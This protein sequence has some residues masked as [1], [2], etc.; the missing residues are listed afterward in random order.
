MMQRLVWLRTI[1]YTYVKNDSD[2]RPGEQL[3]SQSSPEDLA[4]VERQR[5][6]K[7][8]QNGE[9]GHPCARVTKV[10]FLSPR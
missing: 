6:G 2:S 1:L 7:F 5:N 10:G 4:V 8:G 9:L 3:H